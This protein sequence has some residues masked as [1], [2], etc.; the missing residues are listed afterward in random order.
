MSQIKNKVG[1]MKKAQVLELLRTSYPDVDQWNDET[2]MEKGQKAKNSPVPP[3]EHDR[4][5]RSALI[6]LATLD[7]NKASA[8]QSRKAQEE[9]ILQQKQELVRFRNIIDDIH[10]ISATWIVNGTAQDPATCLQFIMQM[11]KVNRELTTTR[12]SKST[13]YSRSAKSTPLP[14]RTP[15]SSFSQPLS[16]PALSPFT[17]AINTPFLST[18]TE[19]R[20]SQSDDQ[21]Q[22]EL[23]L[24]SGFS[25]SVNNMSAAGYVDPLRIFGLNALEDGGENTFGKF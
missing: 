16:Q 18:F 17:P 3:N 7:R 24:E 5:I 11:T 20:I 12:T 19:M 9:T 25:E 2:R 21:P 14:P 8:S 4:L 22:V 13:P 23:G 15:E 1:D 6:R 10:N